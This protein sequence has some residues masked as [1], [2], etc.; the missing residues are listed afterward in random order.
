M[1][2]FK[3]C[4]DCI[5]YNSIVG[6]LKYFNYGPKFTDMIMLLFADFY[7]STQNNRYQSDLFWKKTWCEPG[8]PHKPSNFYSNLRD[9]GAPNKT[10]L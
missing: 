1:V 10:E 9:N 7:I 3:K 8:M 2:D 5:E 4:F 6:A